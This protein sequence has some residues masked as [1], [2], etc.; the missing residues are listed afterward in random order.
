MDKIKK[1]DEKKKKKNGKRNQEKKPKRKINQKK[2][3]EKRKQEKKTEEKKKVN[4]V[5]TVRNL[6]DLIKKLIERWLHAVEP[7]ESNR[8][9]TNLPSHR[10]IDCCPTAQKLQEQYESRL[11]IFMCLLY[12]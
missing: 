12:D 8:Y 11:I 4:K 1:G 5:N 9:S 10:P 7:P 2:K 3:T 6:F